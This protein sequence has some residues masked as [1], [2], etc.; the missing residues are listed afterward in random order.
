M[1]WEV[2][3][4]PAPGQPDL[5]GRPVA[6]AAAELGLADDLAV[7][8]ARG[9]LIQADWDRCQAERVALELLADRVVERVVVAAVGD[10]ELDRIPSQATGPSTTCGAGVSPA[11]AAGD[12]S[13]AHAAGT[14]AP[15]QRG[16]DSGQTPNGA[17][18]LLVHVLPKPGVMDPVA[19][20]VMAA[21]ADFGLQAEAVRTLKKYWI[22][23]LK[24]DRIGA[25]VRQGPGQRRHRAGDRRPLRSPPLELGAP[26]D[27][28]LTT[29]PIRTMDDE[30][31]R[32]Q[33]PRAAL[34]LAGGDADHPGPFPETRPRPDRRRTGDRGPDLER[35]LQPQDARRA[36]PLS[37][38]AIG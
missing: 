36:D 1:L 30:A 29:V 27:F 21:I 34:S 20:S 16:A 23:G 5:L 26:Y 3:I 14:A 11:H 19:Q 8:A 12:V 15:Q 22:K 37:R 38:S 25:A 35:A 24:I 10:E 17:T 6:T 4:Y 18:A 28:R 2:D 31:L 33:P 7:S 13:L 9:Y 32:A